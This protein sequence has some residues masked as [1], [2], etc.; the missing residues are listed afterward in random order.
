LHSC[1]VSISS[2]E[3]LRKDELAMI[4]AK[5]KENKDVKNVVDLNCGALRIQ[6]DEPSDNEDLVINRSHRRL[7]H[8]VSSDEE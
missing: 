6:D 8:I 2:F 4:S 5:E 7:Q 3:F 1:G